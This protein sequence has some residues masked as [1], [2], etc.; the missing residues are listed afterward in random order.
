MIS[1]VRKEVSIDN[2]ILVCVTWERE[3]PEANTPTIE[4]IYQYR[5]PDWDS[6]KRTMGVLTLMSVT[7]RDTRTPIDM[8][9][10]EEVEVL[11][12]ASDHA[13]NQ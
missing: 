1:H 13:E 4:A 2:K 12:L 8:T 9:R 10:E 6:P 3:S 7:R 5:P 11:E